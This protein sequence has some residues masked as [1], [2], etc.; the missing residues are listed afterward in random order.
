MKP[1]DLEV[2]FFVFGKA[3]PDIVG[4]TSFPPQQ[5]GHLL[6]SNLR[7]KYVGRDGLVAHHDT[8]RPF[9][10][11]PRWHLR[12]LQIRERHTTL[13]DDYSHMVSWSACFSLL[14]FFFVVVFSISH[15]GWETGALGVKVHGRGRLTFAAAFA[16]R[17]RLSRYPRLFCHWAW[18]FHGTEDTDP[19]WWKGF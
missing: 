1:K 16:L 10:L 19:D 9:P 5:L 14:P 4:E 15:P 13:N 2:P 11:S 17:V 12:I 8:D 6:S 3:V 7:Y 18:N